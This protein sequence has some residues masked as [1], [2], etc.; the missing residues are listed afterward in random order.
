MSQCRIAPAPFARDLLT[1]PIRSV[2]GI[3]SV[4]ELNL[5]QHKGCIVSFEAIHNPI[6]TWK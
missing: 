2:K 4:T 3:C 6:T 5:H 1:T